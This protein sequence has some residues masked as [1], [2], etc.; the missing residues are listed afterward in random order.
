LT[1]AARDVAATI[2]QIASTDFQSLAANA[3]H[4]LK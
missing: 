2:N 4:K 1:Y 3:L